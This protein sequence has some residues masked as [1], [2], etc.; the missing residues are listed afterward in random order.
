[1]DERI[2]VGGDKSGMVFEEF[3]TFFIIYSLLGG[4]KGCTR[5][6]S[7]LI[8]HSKRLSTQ[9]HSKREKETSPAFTPS[10]RIFLV[11]APK[12]RLDVFRWTVELDG[13]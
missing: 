13:N 11:L 5:C 4:E 3:G 7:P 1:M 12:R 8:L 2:F 6:V 10:S 9:P